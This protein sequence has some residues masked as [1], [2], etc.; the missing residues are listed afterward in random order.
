[1]RIFY[2]FP[3]AFSSFVFCLGFGILFLNAEFIL[4]IS[5]TLFVSLLLRNI[6]SAGLEA[7]QEEI[8]SGF[9]R[10]LC[11]SFERKEKIKIFSILKRKT[12]LFSI[13]KLIGI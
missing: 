8:H 7:K 5:F 10:G 11:G 6:G 13:E 9:Q 2:L 4:A 12:L 1:M 3:F